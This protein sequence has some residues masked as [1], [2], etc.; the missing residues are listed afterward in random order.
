MRSRASFNRTGTHLEA[1]RE[2]NDIAGVA[3]MRSAVQGARGGYSG[4]LICV[5]GARYVR[6]VVPHPAAK[7]RREKI[8]E[9]Q[10]SS[11]DLDLSTQTQSVLGG[12]GMDK[13]QMFGKY[14]VVQGAHISRGS[15][16]ASI[17]T[18]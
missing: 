12:H 18:T 3:A 4:L 7:A 6:T 8:R 14:G 16:V 11:I 15:R 1:R 17:S 13:S 10:V 9:G 5:S 2:N